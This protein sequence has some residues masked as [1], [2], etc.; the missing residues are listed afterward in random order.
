M[1]DGLAAATGAPLE[2]TNDA[3]PAAAETGLV[4]EAPPLASF[5][6][7]VPLAVAA[8]VFTKVLVPVAFVGRCGG[9]SRGS[10]ARG[11]KDAD[12]R[13]QGKL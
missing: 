10:E 5:V 13:D 7:A 1:R 4:L 9:I 8:V 6:P 11:D 3:S 2:G 12:D